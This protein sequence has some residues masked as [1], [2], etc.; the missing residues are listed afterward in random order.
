MPCPCPC[1][2]YVE[3]REDTTLANWWV[4][5]SA[6]QRFW[7]RLSVGRPLAQCECDRCGE[8]GAY[9]R[10]CQ[11]F[12][13]SAVRHEGKCGFCSNW[14]CI[15]LQSNDLPELEDK[16]RKDEPPSDD[17]PGGGRALGEQGGPPPCRVG[18]SLRLAGEAGPW[19]GLGVGVC[20]WVLGLGASS[21]PERALALFELAFKHRKARR[22][23]VGLRV[24]RHRRASPVAAL[25][26]PLRTLGNSL[27]HLRGVRAAVTVC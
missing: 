17:E 13:D 23:E 27:L 25:P 24:T 26:E 8:G 6:V 12:V 22:A 21:T 11:V 3:Q 16:G 9:V 20:F 7:Y 2:R 14:K 19:R 4:K 10:Q 1:E 18:V 15:Q 5:P